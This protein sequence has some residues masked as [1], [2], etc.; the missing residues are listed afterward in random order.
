MACVWKSSRLL[1]TG[2]IAQCR[3]NLLRCVVNSFFHV[4]VNFSLTRS[5]MICEKN[6]STK[7]TLRQN[8]DL[9]GKTSATGSYFSWLEFD[10][11]SAYRR[12]RQFLSV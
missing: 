4:V 2:A 10:E 7:R 5:T 11:F 12:D 3:F 9:A 8:Q 6:P 1:Q